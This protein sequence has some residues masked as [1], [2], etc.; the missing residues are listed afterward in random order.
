[1]NLKMVFEPITIGKVEI[2]NRVLRTAHGTKL[3]KPDINDEFIAYHLERA[4]GGCGLSILEAA[5]VHHS[6]NL[7]LRLFGDAIVPGLQRMMAA[8]RPHG[9]K[10]FQQLWHGGALYYGFSG[11]PWAVS[12]VPSHAGI[13]GQPMTEDMIQELIQAFVQA[14]LICQEGGLDGVEVHAAHGYLFH[15]FLTPAYNTRTDRWGGDFAGRSRFLMEVMRAIRAAVDPGFAVGVR[16]SQSEAPGGVTIEDNHLL[17]DM[18]QAENLIDFADCSLGDYYSIDAMVG[19]MPRDTGYE[20]QSSSRVLEKARVPR[21]VA[22]RF[23]TLEEVDQVLREGVCDMVSMVRAQIADPF[24]V[25]KT[26]AGNPEQV[27]PCLGCNQGCGGS[28]VREGRIGCTV[29]PAVSYEEALSETLIAP[30]AHPRKVMI[31]GG[32]PAGMEAARV[33]RLQGH[34]VTLCEASPQL[35]GQVRVAGLV[36]RLAG[37][38]DIVYWQEQELYRLGVD[39]RLNTYVEADDVRAAGAD[40]VIVA[41]GAWPRMDGFVPGNPGAP[42]RGVDQPHVLSSIDL[43]TDPR[44]DLGKT[45]LVMDSAGGYEAIAVCEYLVEKG[46]AVTLVCIHANMTPYAQ[47]YGREGP[48]VERMMRQGSFQLMLRQQIYEIEPGFCTVGLVHMPGNAMAQVPA[49]TVVLVS[50]NAPMRAL[51]DELRDNTQ[52]WEQGVPQLYLVGDALSPRDVQYG[53]AEAHRVARAL[54]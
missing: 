14:A 23:R 15:Q 27:R 35:G 13:V 39:V 10:M 25:A 28:Q 44:R 50:P 3:A 6:T 36:P 26:L 21:I 16:L 41:T 53:I 22:G 37:L 30:S 34:D 52:G 17:L 54:G 29:N 12:S 11:I 49:D 48:A 4:R 8:I 7:D 46:V 20:L 45:A 2:K 9:M 38:A 19:P 47:T 1:M 42:S 5:S 18:L 24:L 40:V 31:V 32:G 43:I 33:A 51:H